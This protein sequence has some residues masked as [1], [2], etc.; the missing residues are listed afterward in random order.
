VHGL[1]EAG[2]PYAFHTVGSTIVCTPEAY[3]AVSG[4][5]RRQAA[6]D[7]Y[8]LQQL[9]KTG[10]FASI[11][12]TTVYPSARASHRVPF[13]TGRSM[14][15]ALDGERTSDRIYNP[16]SYEVLRECLEIPSKDPG[17][18]L[19]QLEHPELIAFLRNNGFEPAWNRI[20]S[21]AGSARQRTFQFHTWFDAFRTLKLLH[22]LRDNGY[23]NVGV[24]DG[25]AVWGPSG[26][27]AESFL[28]WLRDRDRTAEGISLGLRN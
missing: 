22:H 18:P 3:V 12:F 16:A 27:D 2:S 21:A 23:P 17:L 15:Q 5:N 26:A 4:M 1:R 6:E 9:A 25:A 8:F 28:M 24:G 10:T 11:A 13:G 20:Q 14:T 7:F 19:A